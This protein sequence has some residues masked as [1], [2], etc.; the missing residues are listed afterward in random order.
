VNVD[1]GEDVEI[2]GTNRNTPYIWIADANGLNALRIAPSYEPQW[3]PDGKWLAFLGDVRYDSSGPTGG[4]FYAREVGI[5][6]VASEAVTTLVRDSDLLRALPGARSE[7]GAMVGLAWS[8]DGS[9]L[10]VAMYGPN[11]QPGV[12]VL[13][14]ETGVVRAQRSGVAMWWPYSQR[15]WSPDNRHLAV[16]ATNS[17]QRDTL[18]LFDAQTGQY[19]ELPG[20][21]L[22]WSPDNSIEPSSSIGFDWSP[23]GK[24]LAVTQDPSGLLLLTPDLSSVRWLD[25]PDCFDVAWRPSS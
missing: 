14:A 15:A 17:R 12:W 24:W 10:A 20:A 21:S 3:S 6:D 2:T 11:V 16:W 4:F 8:P 7:N 18:A 25:T 22:D 23:D 13:N 19:A 5:A 1:T 9:M